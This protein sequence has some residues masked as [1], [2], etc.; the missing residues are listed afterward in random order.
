MDNLKTIDFSKVT[1]RIQPDN[2]LAVQLKAFADFLQKDVPPDKRKRIG[3]QAAFRD[4][5]PIRNSDETLEL[6]F[7]SYELGEPLHTPGECIVRGMTYS[8][9]LHVTFHLRSIENGR[10]KEIAEQKVYFGEFPMMTETGSF[11]FNG[12]ERVIVNQIHRS[13]GVIF[14][15]DE[16]QKVSIY[17]KRLYVARIIPYRGSW[18]EFEFEPDGKLMVVVDKRRKFPVTTFLRACGI[19]DEELILELFAD[20]E[21]IEIK[22]DLPLEAL[23]GKF[24][25]EEI[26][27]KST[28][29]IIVEVNQEITKDKVNSIFNKNIKKVRV[30]K[31]PAILLS[32]RDELRTSGGQL[33][34]P[35][36]EKDPQKAKENYQRMAQRARVQI[37]QVLKS[38]EYS[39]PVERATNY[40]DDLFFRSTRRY[41][42]TRIGRFKIN[43]KLEGIFQEYEKRFKEGDLKRFAEQKIFDWKTPSF[44]HRLLTR[45]DIIATI[46][47]LLRISNGDITAA[48][49]DIDHLGNR[50]VRTVSE[51]LE[52]QV[53]IALYTMSR[54]I[55]EKMNTI[56]KDSEELKPRQ[57][58]NFSVFQAL[59]KK[60]FGTSQLSQFLDQTNPLAELTHKRRLSAL[61]PG[62]LNRKRAG[63]EVRDVHYTHY[64]RICPIETP[65]GGNIGLIS[66]LGVYSRLNEYGLIETPYRV[67]KNGRLTDEIRYFTADAEDEVII[68]QAN[69]RVDKNGKI[70]DDLVICRYRG[71]VIAVPPEKVNYIDITPIQVVGASAS[72]IPFLEH[73]DA[74]RA[75]MGSNMQRQAVPL[76]FPEVPLV[77]TGMERQ[78]AVDSKAVV[79]A[80]RDGLVVSVDAREILV[81]NEEDKEIDR[82]ILRKYERSN[83]DTCINQIPRVK[84]GQRVRKGQV[85]AD[86]MATSYG[87]LALGKN[88]LV[89]FVPWEGYNFEDAI[90]VSERLLRDNVFTSVHISEFTC[91]ARE[92]RGRAEEITRDIPN[93]SSDELLN[94]GEDGIVRIGTEVQPYDILV[95]K[96]A[97]KGEQQSSPE[98]RLLRVLFGHKSEDVKDDSLRVPPGVTGK[99]IGVQVFVSREK[100][101]SKKSAK[102]KNKTT[103]TPLDKEIALRLSELR[104][105]RDRLKDFLEREKEG[106]L[107]EA[108]KAEQEL[109]KLAYKQKIEQIDKYYKKEEERIKKGEELPIAVNKSVKVYIATTRYLQVGDKLAGRHGNKGVI[110]R[111]V[112]VEDMPYL[113]DGTPVDVLLSPLSVPSRMNV[114]QLLEA[115]LGWAAKTL[116]V[117]CITPVFSGATE[118]EVKEKIKE[119]RQ[120]L[121]KKGV[122]EKYLPDENCQ[123]TL[124]DGRTGEPFM[125]KATIGYMYLMKLIHMVDDKIHARSTGPYALITRQ[126]LGGK[127]QFGGQ[128]FGEMEVWALEGYGAAHTLREFLTIK[129]DDESGRI[130]SYEAITHGKDFPTSGVP[131]TFRVLVSELRALGLNVELKNISPEPQKKKEAKVKVAE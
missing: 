58:V 99:V 78:V 13:P 85:I 38:Q 36:K 33:E 106:R 8:A 127:A 55:R 122:P 102:G 94:L 118:A 51:L 92:T 62:G 25:G 67:V 105:E 18:V 54:G 120:Y 130:A 5:F 27:D 95:G 93:T 80:R 37:Y 46:A 19:E 84:V 76:L 87:Q 9:P 1:A 73:D 10:F 45:Q 50:R 111:I 113:P 112:R 79:L 24:A 35:R 64:G 86:G 66:S 97:P 11:V 29:E 124:Y 71:D 74:N 15:E 110:A 129:S 126:P 81:V 72:L 69:T 3:L 101:S 60:F 128:R 91:E 31:N 42:L 65:E 48:E 107:K 30:H 41:D 125:E 14:E 90:V 108:K 117:Q 121:L 70:L 16:E 103:P 17:G 52:N 75:L 6:D 114:G 57:L 21:E 32:L 83:Q 100:I 39:I 26:V 44:E 4:T 119:A 2:L 20:Y 123:I 59:I 12:A 96:T 56:A 89:A 43:R 82:Y 88:L 7:V 53:R 104:K 61:G 98:E 28:G 77:A 47:Y 22:P 23:V 116:N 109:I 115:I 34:L 68:A 49:D 63:F 131:E 40:L